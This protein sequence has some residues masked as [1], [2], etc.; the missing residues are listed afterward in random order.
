M[1][2]S[3]CFKELNI[4]RKEG[5]RLRALNSLE[6]DMKKRN[7]KTPELKNPGFGFFWFSGVGNGVPT[8]YYDSVLALVFALFLGLLAIMIIRGESAL[9]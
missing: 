2:S 1:V 6:S 7:S 4:L 3:P 5:V 9:Y 8:K